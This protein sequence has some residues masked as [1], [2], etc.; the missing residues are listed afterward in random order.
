MA[1]R[2]RTSHVAVLV[3]WPA[4]LDHT[5]GGGHQVI[6]GR[7]GRCC[8]VHN[9]VDAGCTESDRARD[10]RHRRRQEH[11]RPSHT[12]VPPAP[13]PVTRANAI[14]I[15]AIAPPQHCT[16]GCRPAIDLRPPRTICRL[17]QHVRCGRR[18]SAPRNGEAG[19]VAVGRRADSRC[20]GGGVST[21][22]PVTECDSAAPAY[23]GCHAPLLRRA[24]SSYSLAPL[25]TL[26]PA[27]LQANAR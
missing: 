21:S 15:A 3:I 12:R 16:G 27:S 11:R 17:F 22:I 13:R 19:G 7:R 10:R 2:T 5:R 20:E 24:S 23:T 14:G 1:R 18:R 8:P 9:A 4:V 25:A 6:A 26:Q